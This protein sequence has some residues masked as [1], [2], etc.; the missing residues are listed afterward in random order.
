[1]RLH[2]PRVPQ[3]AA[4]MLI[5]LVQGKDIETDAPNEVKA[6]IEA[7][8]SQYVR[9][10]Q[11]VGEKAKDMMAARGLSQTEYPRPR[12]ARRRREATSASSAT[13]PSTTC[14]ISWSRC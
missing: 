2:G 12:E 1:M 5:A 6:D 4:E 7:V 9:D 14:S 8:L 11:A 3:I 10:E 13:M